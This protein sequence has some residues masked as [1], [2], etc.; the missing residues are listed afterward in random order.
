MSVSVA[1]EPSPA[2][3]SRLGLTSGL[4]ARRKQ[5]TPAADLPS[6]ADGGLTIGQGNAWHGNSVQPLMANERV[7]AG[8]EGF[9]E[10]DDS[11]QV[12]SVESRLSELR[13]LVEDVAHSGETRYSKDLTVDGRIWR[14]SVEHLPG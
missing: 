14:V 8:G 4:E 7:S 6:S 2:H 5:H 9:V 11:S 3:V 10:F 13:G 12:G 1:L